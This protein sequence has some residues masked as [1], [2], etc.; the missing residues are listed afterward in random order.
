MSLD[1]TSL[2]PMSVDRMSFGPMSVDLVSPQL[3]TMFFFSFF[4]N[5]KCLVLTPLYLT[6]CMHPRPEAYD[7]T[8]L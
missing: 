3:L 7:V 1:P 5:A 2:G 6:Y 4:T 8:I